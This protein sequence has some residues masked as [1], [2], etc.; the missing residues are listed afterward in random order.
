VNPTT[1][2]LELNLHWGQFRAYR[3]ERR[4]VAV[5]AG[6]QSGKTSFGPFWL[7]R[8]IQQAG[9]GDYLVVTPT[10]Q[11][12]ERKALPELKRLFERQLRLGRYVASPSRRFEFSA[13]GS[14]KCF[15]SY[16][17]DTPTTVWFGYAEDPESLESMTAK[18][19]W[20]DEAG[21]RKFKLQ[22]WEAVLR[23][24]SL[25]RGRALLTTTPYD[26][27]WLKQQLYDPWRAVGG[28]HPEIDWVNFDSTQNPLFPQ[29]EWE[30]A[31]ATLPRWKFDLFYRG[32]LVRPAGLIYDSF[33]DELQPHGHLCGRFPIPADWK[34]LL[35]LDF[36]Q[37]NM[38]AGFYAQ[39]PESK[40]LYLYR[41]YHTGGRSVEKHVEA[42]LRG[43]P[44]IPSA[45]G[46]ATSEDEWRR[47]FAAA[48][49]PVTQPSISEV[50]VGIDSVYAAHAEGQIIVFADLMEYREQKV[51]YSR[52]L[53]LNQEPTEK[54][55]DKHTFHLMDAER[56]LISH[57][58]KGPRPGGFSLVGKARP[59]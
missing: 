58:R 43:E 45:V 51:T 5:V 1:G 26:V 39:H 10:F 30:R 59:S 11:L 22:S 27:G 54:I 28:A 38:A 25:S 56:Y 37:V 53:D 15:G 41:T 35:G 3:S 7:Y 9:P 23:R 42:L 57:L 18:A 19:A 46:G 52:E 4:F 13:E 32:L 16:D 29:A 21:Q 34:R 8:E 40:V 33:R 48:G 24:L 20:L 14:R 17:P 49:L 55:A 6:T 2:K 50:E 47:K 31:K 44:G 12:L 36:G